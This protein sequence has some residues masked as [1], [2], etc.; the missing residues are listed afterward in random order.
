MK[1]KL[2][3]LFIVTEPFSCN[4][5]GYLSVFPGQVVELLEEG[6]QYWLVCTLASVKGELES[7]GFIPNNCLTQLT[8]GEAIELL[9]FM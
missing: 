4:K 2:K 5:E 6:Q 7:E 9:M 1:E 8:E 3:N